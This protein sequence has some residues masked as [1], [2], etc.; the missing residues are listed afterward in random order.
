M[1]ILSSV[2][3]SCDRDVRPTQ[4]IK[5]QQHTLCVL[6]L[7]ELLSI[8]VAHS[9]DPEY[10]LNSKSVRIG[11]PVGGAPLPVRKAMLSV[12]PPASGTEFGALVSDET[13]NTVVLRIV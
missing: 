7:I 12:P 2:S 6:Q 10:R 8:F 3:E 13:V 11:P 4:S 9:F 1:P 5:V